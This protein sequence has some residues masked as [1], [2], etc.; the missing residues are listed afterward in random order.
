MLLKATDN[1]GTSVV[2][3]EHVFL[4]KENYKNRVQTLNPLA[5]Y[6]RHKIVNV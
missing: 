1:V 2:I 6:Y 4:A 3:F 5:T